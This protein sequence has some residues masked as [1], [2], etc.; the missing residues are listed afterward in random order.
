[1][2]NKNWVLMLTVCALCPVMSL[3]VVVRKDKHE[4]TVADLCADHLTQFP[5]AEAP[6]K[7]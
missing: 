2:G 3:A 4:L 6:V 1:M 7:T 5:R